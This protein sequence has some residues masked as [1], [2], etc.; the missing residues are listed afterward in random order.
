MPLLVGGVVDARERLVESKLLEWLQSGAMSWRDGRDGL[1]L[2]CGDLDC[3]VFVE[4]G[5]GSGRL[6][7]DVALAPDQALKR[8]GGLLCPSGRYSLSGEIYSYGLVAIA[9]R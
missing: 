9:V 4:D 3:C 1:L 7:G 2:E 6:K 5:G 8:L